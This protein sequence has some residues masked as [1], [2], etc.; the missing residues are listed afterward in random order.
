MNTTATKSRLYIVKAR[1]GNG[2]IIK[3]VLTSQNQA[4]RWTELVKKNGYT[5]VA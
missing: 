5:I 4:D 2:P 3:Q 1:K